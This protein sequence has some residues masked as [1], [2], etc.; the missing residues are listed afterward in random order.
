M[1]TNELMRKLSR[2]DSANSYTIAWSIDDFLKVMG[3][4]SFAECTE[5]LTVQLPGIGETE[6]A[7]G[8]SMEDTVGWPDSKNLGYKG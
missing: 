7:L 3:D 2:M 8:W 6:W 1:S 4:G 5:T